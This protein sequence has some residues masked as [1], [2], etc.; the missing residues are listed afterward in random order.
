MSDN[1]R[2]RLSSD[3]WRTLSW[4][5]PGQTD[6]RSRSGCPGTGPAVRA[7]SLTPAHAALGP[8]GRA[9]SA[10]CVGALWQTLSE[11]LGCPGG[12]WDRLS[13][14][15]F[16]SPPAGR[17][18][19]PRCADWILHLSSA[20]WLTVS[21]DAASGVLAERWLNR[22][23]GVSGV[24]G[25]TGYRRAAAR[26]RSVA[27]AGPSG[28]LCTVAMSPWLYTYTAPTPTNRRP[29]GSRDLVHV[30]RAAEGGRGRC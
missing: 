28:V 5:F 27:P 11:P 3:L 7:L 6:G 22:I 17:R 15:D 30:D 16:V 23:G 2:D 9:C 18:K 14:S 8:S 4:R 13:Y 10:S 24:Q 19:A 21:L 20:P 29:N 26:R 12:Q 1:P 25:G